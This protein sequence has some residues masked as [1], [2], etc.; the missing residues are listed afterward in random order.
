MWYLVYKF[1][2]RV[3][4]MSLKGSPLFIDQ[5]QVFLKEKN[6]NSKLNEPIK[7]R[8]MSKNTS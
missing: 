2:V 1:E 6:S 5:A 3:V 4:R 7:K 8:H